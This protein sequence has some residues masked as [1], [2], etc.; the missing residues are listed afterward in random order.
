MDHSITKKNTDSN[1]IITDKITKNDI[2]S[3]KVI[4]ND[5]SP[6]TIKRE[7]SRE[8]FIKYHWAWVI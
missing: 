7:K 3:T 5:S 6:R 2:K 8:D 1:E 4:C